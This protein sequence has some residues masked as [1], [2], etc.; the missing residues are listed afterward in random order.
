MRDNAS[1]WGGKTAAAWG[2]AFAASSLGI[3]ADVSTGLQGARNVL[4][5][6]SPPRHP[7]NPLRDIGKWA[8][9]TAQAYGE[10]FEMMKPRIAAN[11]A[12]TLS[13]ANT[14]RP[15]P[16]GAMAPLAMRGGGG[17]VNIAFH[18]VMPPTPIG[19]REVVRA[20]GPELRRYLANY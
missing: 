4:Q 19:A 9:R 18:S 17:T 8:E 5:A 14:I 15:A 1:I 2:D 11:V 12:G 10:H 6:F 7:M 3:A 20:I 16:G 13:L